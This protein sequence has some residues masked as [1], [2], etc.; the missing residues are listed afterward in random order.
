MW[1]CDVWQEPSS[2]T[3][4]GEPSTP[5]VCALP[6]RSAAG[7]CHPA[8]PAQGFAP[9]CQTARHQCGVAGPWEIS[10][11][12]LG[13]QG[14]LAGGAAQEFRTS[15]SNESAATDPALLGFVHNHQP[16]CSFPELL[17]L[18]Q[19]ST[20]FSPRQSATYWPGLSGKLDVIASLPPQVTMS[21]M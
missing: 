20:L 11:S 10:R 9:G 19:E 15:T 5:P 16:T 21:V 6:S 4:P 7:A 14:L 12:G 8:P 2:E 1:S 18:H 13:H 17:G 3:A